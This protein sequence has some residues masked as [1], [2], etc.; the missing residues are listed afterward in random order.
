MVEGVS[1]GGGPTWLYLANNWIGV[2]LENFAP[3]VFPVA[4]KWNKWAPTHVPASWVPLI[5]KYFEDSS[6]HWELGE[7]RVEEGAGLGFG[8]S[9]LLL[10]SVVAAGWCWLRKPKIASPKPPDWVGRL[11]CIGSWVS[12]FVSL[13]NLGIAGVA[14]YC[15]PYYV[16]AVAGLLLGAGHYSVVRRRWWHAWAW[17]SFALAAMLLVVSQARP[18]WPAR[19]ALAHLGERFR[20]SSIGTRVF[21]VYEVYGDRADAFGP[22]RKSLPADASPLGLITFDDP[23]TSLWRP[24]GLRRILHVKSIDTGGEV[25]ARGIKYVLVNEQKTGEPFEQWLQRMNGR[26]LETRE[27]RLRAGKPPFVW[28]LVELN[29]FEAQQK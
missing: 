5:D 11:V 22:I 14:R 27:L 8:V 24:F 26:L 15:T 12:L 20:T 17:V 21:T 29:P 23:E 25:R 2:G 9:M 6:A 7:L 16:P 10:L 18:L 13:A 4:S 1:I 19:W 3:P 28:H